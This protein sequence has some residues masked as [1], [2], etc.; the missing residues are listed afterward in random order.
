M[1]TLTAIYHDILI[2]NTGAHT[3]PV[4]AYEEN[5]ITVKNYLLQHYHGEVI[6]R[7]TPR[8][9]INCSEYDQKPIKQSND[10][11][12]DY[13]RFLIQPP[14][15]T[16]GSRKYELYSYGMFPSYNNISKAIFND[17]DNITKSSSPYHFIDIAPIMELRPDIHF[18]PDDCLHMNVHALDIWLQLLYNALRGN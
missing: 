2:L 16:D 4:K 15:D 12:S 7:T 13:Y 6:Y 9:H 17:D 14:P 3:R 10:T 11:Q 5:L 8:G 18:P 1:V